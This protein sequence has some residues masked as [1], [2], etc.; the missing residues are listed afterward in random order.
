[1][2]SI[3]FDSGFNTEY[4]GGKVFP[5]AR[6]FAVNGPSAGGGATFASPGFAGGPLHDDSSSR[7]L[8]SAAGDFP[9]NEPWTGLTA[10]A[11]AAGGKANFAAPDFEG[12]PPQDS[13]CLHAST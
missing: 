5:V 3:H 13:S 2:H 1:M 8:F 6:A 7:R 10:S 9:D 4:K 12:G 11:S